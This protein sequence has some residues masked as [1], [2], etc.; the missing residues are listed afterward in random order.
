MTW[1]RS[2]PE[3]PHIS[4]KLGFRRIVD[5][6]TQQDIIAEVNRLSSDRNPKIWLGIHWLARYI[7][8]R[9]GELINIK[10]KD[11]DLER[12][13]IF[14]PHP[15]EGTPKWVPM[16]KEDVEM[17]RAYKDAY[18]GFPDQHFFRSCKGE[19]GVAPDVPFNQKRLPKWWKKACANVSVHGVDL[20]G[21]TR[22]S[23]ATALREFCT[24]EEIKRATMHSTNQAFERYFQTDGEELRKI[25]A[26]AGS[27]NRVQFPKAEEGREF[28]DTWGHN[29]GALST[30]ALPLSV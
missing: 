20:Y 27:D 18:P 12:G 21:G 24:P 1:G 17:A 10:E 13:S 11:I 6:Q 4:Y 19:E 28:G 2:V 9:P 3:I 5:K 14:I 7:S 22:H 26:I 23:S 29:L 16:V 25:Y 30:D 15:K 8:I